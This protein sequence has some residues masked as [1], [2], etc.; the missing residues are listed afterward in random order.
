M[1]VILGQF[2]HNPFSVSAAA[3]MCPDKKNLLYGTLGLG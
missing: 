2:V 1:F 3:S